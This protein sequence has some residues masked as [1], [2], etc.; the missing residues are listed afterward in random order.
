MATVVT[1]QVVGIRED[2]VDAVYQITPTDT[3]F[4][5]GIAQVKSAGTYHEWETDA[6][7]A[8]KNNVTPEGVD[9]TYAAYVPKV[10]LGNYTQIHTESF[11]VSGTV[12]K[13]NTAGPGEIARLQK[14]TMLALKKDV[15]YAALLNTVTN[16]AAAS[17]QMKGVLGWN[18]TNYFGGTG[19]V[20]PVAGNPGT[21]PVAGTGRAFTEELL[22][23]ALQA[24]Y[25]AGGEVD[26]LILTPAGKQVVSGFSGNAPRYQNVA[27]SGEKTLRTSFTFYESDFGVVKCVP[28]RVITGAT[29]VFGIDSEK[30]ALGV[31]RPF[32]TEQLA[33]TGD[34]VK[35]QNVGEFTLEAR[36]E[37]AS[38]T[39]ADLNNV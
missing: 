3:P 2:L 13:A 11:S 31:Y 18:H 6:L 29:Q 28:N 8:A 9:A 1:N 37:A 20:A 22:K 39:I 19:A 10:R 4:V 38:F 14:N 12:Q 33:K 25:I 36:N 16:S 7:R 21:A 34:S 15:E 32:S 23:S 24:T 5:S 27:D 30:W 26:T 17:R 35:Y